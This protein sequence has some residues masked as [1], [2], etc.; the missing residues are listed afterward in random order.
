MPA[1][2]TDR[3]CYNGQMESNKAITKSSRRTGIRIGKFAIIGIIL[4]L[5]NFVIYTFLA[6]VI[7]NNNELLWLDSIISYALATVLAYILHS[8]I[9]WKER[10]VT[11][12]GIIMFFIWNGI[13]AIA[14]SPLCT[15]VFAQLKPFYEF[16]HNI[17]N[18]IH[19]PFDYN[20]IESTTVFIL[21]NVV[22]MVLNYLFYD[23]LVFGSVK[24]GKQKQHRKQP[25][26]KPNPQKF[27]K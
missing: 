15:W 2:Y 16:L 5:F 17:S 18:F 6:R 23:R 8:K 12:K 25:I 22:T 19:L 21:V 7:F 9:T 13:T 27:T 10:P 24:P 4:A 3:S 1:H 14:I 26:N 11:S 20:F